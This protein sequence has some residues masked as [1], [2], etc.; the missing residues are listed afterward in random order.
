MQET[1]YQAPSCLLAKTSLACTLAVASVL[2]TGCGQSQSSL[3]TEPLGNTKV[4]VL[5]SSTSGDELSYFFIGITGMTLTDSSGNSVSLYT[6]GPPNPNTG[7]LNPAEFIHLNGALEPLV[8]ASIPQGTYVSAAVQV[9]RCSISTSVV[10]PGNTT[11]ATTGECDTETQTTVNLPSPIAVSGSAMALSLNLQVPLSYTGGQAAVLALNTTVSPYFIL[12]PIQIAAPPSN[13]QNGLITGVTVQ[14]D[15]VSGSSIAAQTLDGVSSTFS[16]GG[17]T[18]YQG[19]AGVSS[20][21]PGIL[22]NL[23]A[24]IQPDGSL[25]ATRIEADDPAAAYVVTGPTSFGSDLLSGQF[26]LLVQQGIPWVPAPGGLSIPVGPEGFQSSG[27]TTFK[28]SGQLSNLQK[29]PFSP[30]FA[31]QSFFT[32]QN[33]ATFF[34]SQSATANSGYQRAAAITLMPQTINGTVSAVLSSS[35]GFAVY[36][37][38]IDTDDLIYNLQAQPGPFPRIDNPAEIVVYAD[39]S[40][41]MLGPSVITAGTA[42]RFRGLLFDDNGVLRL[43][44]G[45]ILSGVTAQSSTGFTE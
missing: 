10:T 3:S 41:Q 5:L 37:V 32:G 19:V 45:Q 16:A 43:D 2:M 44:C 34:S 36:D 28:I 4:V 33:V 15:S 30:A 1:H 39:S 23:D 38:L 24:A 13:E 22:V 26:Q 12:T 40:T 42:A 21:T 31:A 20:L 17:S 29:L 35:N 8:T 27:A 25:L 11:T 18:V 7:A 9:N 6:K 14:V